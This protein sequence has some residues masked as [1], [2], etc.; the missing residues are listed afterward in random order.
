MLIRDHRLL[1][2]LYRLHRHLFPMSSSRKDRINLPPQLGHLARI[3][4]LLLT[5]LPD[6]ELPF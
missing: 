2:P 4:N 6:P 3:Q 5:T 1:R